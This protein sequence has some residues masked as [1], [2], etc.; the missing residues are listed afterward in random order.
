MIE[1]YKSGKSIH[2]CLVNRNLC[3]T[4]EN[5]TKLKTELKNR[6]IV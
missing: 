3:G 4:G 1:D 5:H 2:Y 6:G